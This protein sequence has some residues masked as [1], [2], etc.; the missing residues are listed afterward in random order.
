MA[1]VLVRPLLLP[2]HSFDSLAAIWQP[3]AA[4]AASPAAVDP[5]LRPLPPSRPAWPLSRAHTCRQGA[6]QR[7][8]LRQ[9]ARHKEREQQHCSCRVARHRAPVARAGPAGLRRGTRHGGRQRREGVGVARGGPAARHSLARGRRE[10]DLDAPAP[11]SVCRA[12]RAGRPRGRGAPPPADLRGPA[13][14]GA[15]IST[16]SAFYSSARPQ[17][18]PR[19]CA[20]GWLRGVCARAGASAARCRGSKGY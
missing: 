19:T 7:R 8:L 20:P 11:A 15:R 2:S 16:L 18:P 14:S 12:G 13:A 5:R 6:A 17:A 1:G 3:S 10:D 4:R 9:R